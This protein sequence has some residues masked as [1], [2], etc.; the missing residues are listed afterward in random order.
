MSDSTDAETKN[1]PREATLT[2]GPATPTPGMSVNSDTAGAL[3]NAVSA[4]EA[5]TRC[6]WLSPSL[7]KR[8]WVTE[9]ATKSRPTRAPAT[10][11]AAT[12][13]SWK[14]SGVTD[15][16]LGALDHDRRGLHGRRRL[17]PG[18]QPKLLHRVTRDRRG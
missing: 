15:E 3:E 6:S 7:A 10:P 5:R 18:R 11:A 9:T 16:A 1:S 8:S 2:S 12:K 14:L 4:A 17:D 13:K